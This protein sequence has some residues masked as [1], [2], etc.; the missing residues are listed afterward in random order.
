[1]FRERDEAFCGTSLLQVSAAQCM[2]A[3]RKKKNSGTNPAS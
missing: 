3:A 2:P 1:M